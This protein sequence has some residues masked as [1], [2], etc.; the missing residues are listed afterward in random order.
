MPC[1]APA[2]SYLAATQQPR[3]S[4]RGN[5][6]Q[7]HDDVR[8]RFS[9]GVDGEIRPIPATASASGDGVNRPESSTPASTV[10]ITPPLVIAPCCSAL[11]R[12]QFAQRSQRAGPWHSPYRHIRIFMYPVIHVIKICSVHRGVVGTDCSGGRSQP[13]NIRWLR[14]L[15]LTGTTHR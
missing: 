10:P 3:A 12:A 7:R 6:A 2:G 13:V 8:R 9:C 4:S 14:R 15:G 11:C 5:I 1:E